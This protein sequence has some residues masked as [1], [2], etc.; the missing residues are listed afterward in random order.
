MDELCTATTTG[1]FEILCSGVLG[2]AAKF[3]AAFGVVIFSLQKQLEVAPSSWWVTDS[4]FC[5]SADG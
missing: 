1:V 5:H 4:K 2:A 3:E